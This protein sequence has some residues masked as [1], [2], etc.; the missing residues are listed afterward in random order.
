[1]S[2]DVAYARRQIEEDIRKGELKAARVRKYVWYERWKSVAATLPD[3]REAV[4]T[5]MFQLVDEARGFGTETIA[6]SALAA[7]HVFLMDEGSH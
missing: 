1:M 2:F 7:L 6:W 3:G 4:L 5:K